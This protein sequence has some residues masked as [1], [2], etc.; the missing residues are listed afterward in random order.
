MAWPALLRCHDTQYIGHH[1]THHTLMFPPPTFRQGSDIIRLFKIHAISSYLRSTA[2]EYEMETF[3][4]LLARESSK[5][6]MILVN[7][8]SL[9]GLY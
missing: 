6:F 1:H 9:L 5:S 7:L 3:E 2:M 4:M 8:Q